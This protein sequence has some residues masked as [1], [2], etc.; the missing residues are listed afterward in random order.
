MAEEKK[1][2]LGGFISSLAERLK[3]ECEGTHLKC[4]RELAHI[5]EVLA[6]RPAMDDKLTRV[7]KILHA[8]NEAKRA[9][10]LAARLRKTAQILIDEVGADGPMNAED[11]AKRA[12]AV[13]QGLEEFAR[14]VGSE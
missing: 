4:S 10:D 13:I 3:E 2:G 7:D 5:D 9:D 12:V 6:R 8:I 11:A 1:D 14:D